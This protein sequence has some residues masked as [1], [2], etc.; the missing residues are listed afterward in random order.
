MDHDEVTYIFKGCIDIKLKE[1]EKIIK[2]TV[3]SNCEE[4]LIRTS[5]N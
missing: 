3:S 2:M 1:K 5:K 4:V